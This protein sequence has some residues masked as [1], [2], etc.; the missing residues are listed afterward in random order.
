MSFSCTIKTKTQD[1]TEQ[2]IIS[3]GLFGLGPNTLE[4]TD[5]PC[6]LEDFRAEVSNCKYGDEFP[7]AA[8]DCFKALQMMARANL[9]SVKRNSN[10][11]ETCTCPD[12]IIPKGWDTAAIERLL[13][14]DPEDVVY[15]SGGY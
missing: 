7:K 12:H 6:R 1:L 11:C 9:E 4:S 14:I 10:H 13:E 8:R 2:D 15:V 5:A 3:Y